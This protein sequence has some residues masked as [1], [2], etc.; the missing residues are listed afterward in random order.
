MSYEWHVEFALR[1]RDRGDLQNVVQGR[2]A[3]SPIHDLYARLQLLAQ[4]VADANWNTDAKSLSVREE[5]PPR[6]S[7][8]EIPQTYQR[9]TLRY[10]DRPERTLYTD[11]VQQQLKTY[12]LLG[13]VTPRLGE[14]DLA[15]LPPF[16]FFL[17]LPF[18]LAA[19][20]LSKDDEPFYVHENPLR[21]EHTLRVPLMESTSWKGA[22]R[23]ALRYRLQAEDADP[24]LVR[25]LGNPKGADEGFCRG[26]L[27]FFPTFFDA[28][29]VE[30][31]N[32]H[33]RQTSAGSQPIHMEAVPPGARGVFALLY[34]PVTTPPA[35][36]GPD[37]AIAL[38]DLMITLRT[39]YTLLME[40][41]FGAKTASGM[42]RAASEIPEVK[43]T[44]GYLLLHF[45]EK[46]T[47]QR[48]E[49]A[50]LPALLEMSDAI[51]KQQGG[52]R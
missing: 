27:I 18:T 6:R 38:E 43:G 46:E 47:P 20:Y 29:E 13:F 2:G 1:F 49:F 42:G 33:S 3:F 16:S 17:Y 26:R 9:L 7:K 44:R 31:I 11:F 35:D 25:L 37:R 40:R 50:T 36:A 32:P 5:R 45:R 19:P 30:V 8:V 4:S 41:G 15:L 34:V 39:A 24:R 12:A 22:F 10:H 51:R 23:A 28:L 52:E 14:A 21:K 48:R